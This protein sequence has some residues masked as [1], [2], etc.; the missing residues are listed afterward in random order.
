MED[1]TA[2]ATKTQ[3][4]VNAVLESIPPGQEA[5]YFRKQEEI[6]LLVEKAKLES[7]LPHI[8]GW[9]WYKWA[10]EFFESRN[11]MNFLCAANQI[12]KSSTQIRK[13]I[14]WATNQDLWPS[15]WRSRPMQ[16]WYLYPS[17]DVTDIEFETKWKLFLPKPELKEHPIY[18]WWE[19]KRNKH[20]FAI[21]FNSGVHVYFKT[22][23][24]DVQHLQTGT[25]DAIFCDEELPVELL[26]ELLLRLAAT[27]GYFH[28]VFTATLGQ[29]YW[30]KTIEPSNK[31]EE[32]Y[33]DAFKLQVSMYDCLFYED[34]TPSHWTPEKISRQ[35]KLCSTRAQVQRRIH[36]KFAVDEGLVYESFDRTRNMKPRRP[37]QQ[38][39]P[40]WH[41]YG[42]ADVG[43]GG[44]T[45]H[46]AAVVFIAVDPTY[47][48]G[49]VFKGW[50]GDKITTTAGDVVKKFIELRGSFTMA[51]QL[52]DPACKDFDTIASGMNEGFQAAQKGHETGEYTVN[53][54]FK[55][56][57]L[58][59]Y[60]GDP[61]LEKLAAELETLRRDTP[62]NKAADDLADNV[63]YICSEIPWDF[64][65]ITGE[66]TLEEKQAAMEAEEERVPHEI[67]ER[68][69]GFDGKEQ[70]VDA[71]TA[72]IEEFNELY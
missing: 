4:E 69:A 40:D 33:P 26:D 53:V 11:R 48:Q 9:N 64:T 72:E 58:W 25:C 21:H 46:P 38:V 50:R 71:I 2:P 3:A 29:A 10:K 61:E 41:I 14:E 36:G 68:R 51:A 55:N 56:Q 65:F 62:K 6:A 37:D 34:G 20:L 12:S 27:D 39:P 49:R 30:K 15:L 35:I 45:G 5:E 28:M 54:L 16:F 57:M 43:S 7:N 19:E 52:Y 31:E 63:R 47:R 8:Y 18:G 42:C 59:I 23:Q 60:E 70:E 44:P 1:L 66:P 22:Y 67:R 24:Q 17:K 13:C 32:L